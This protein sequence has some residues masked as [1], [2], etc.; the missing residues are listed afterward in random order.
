MNYLAHLWLTEQ[1]GLPLAGAI[2]GD[3]VHGRLDGRF[4]DALERSIRLHRRVDAVT[5]SHPLVAE[6]RAGFGPGARRYAGIVLDLVHDHALVLDWD[7]Y[8]G[9]HLGAFA[10]RAAQA[11][12]AEKDGFRLAAMSPPPAWRFRRLL[13]SYGRESGIDQAM[14]RVASRLKRPQA[15][16]EAGGN[17]RQTLPQVREN[18][19][20]L[21]H[22]LRAAALELARESA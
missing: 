8:S 11:V 12:A 22:D 9:E 4:P 16:L 19:P 10:R 1:A 14:R 6:Q 13:L 21:L 18:L 3:L 15:L 17:W 20:R 5:D 2:L 7:R